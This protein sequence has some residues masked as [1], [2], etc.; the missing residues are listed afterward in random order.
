MVDKLPIS[1]H[2]IVCG[3]GIIGQKIVDVLEENNVPFIIIDSDESK[4]KWIIEKGFNVVHG[5][6]TISSTLKSASISSAKA[7]AIVMDNDAKDLFTILT[8]RDLNKDIFIVTRANDE[9]LREKLIDAGADYVTLPQKS[10]SNQILK[11]FG[12]V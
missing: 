8:A 3:Y 10:A 7:I 12:L 2:V 5:D 9:F 4:V 6:A 11:E 1:N